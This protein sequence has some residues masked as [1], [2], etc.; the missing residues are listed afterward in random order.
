MKTKIIFFLPLAVLLA[1]P[2]GTMAARP[3]DQ[4][5]ICHIPPGNPSNAHAITVG[6][7][8]VATHIAQHGDYLG[9][10]VSSADACNSCG[11]TNSDYSSS[12]SCVATCGIL[13]K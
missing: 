13:L 10:C 6:V 12:T 3:E 4:V 8:A 1:L 5:T 9:D 7:S 2:A 11:Y